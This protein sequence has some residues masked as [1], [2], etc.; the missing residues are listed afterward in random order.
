ME[1]IF[2]W[3]PKEIAEKNQDMFQ[4]QGFFET[5][6]DANSIF[7]DSECTHFIWGLTAANFSENAI[8]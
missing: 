4:S 3:E 2:F 6:T 5:E 1:Y 8:Q 7:L